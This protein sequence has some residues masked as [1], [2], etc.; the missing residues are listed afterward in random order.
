MPSSNVFRSQSSHVALLLSTVI[1]GATV[2]HLEKRAQP[3]GIDVSSYQSD[4]N[5]RTPSPRAFPSPTSERQKGPVRAMVCSCRTLT[6]D[7]SLKEPV[8]TSPSTLTLPML[9]SFTVP[10]TPPFLTSSPALLKQRF[11][12]PTVETGR[13]MAS[14]FQGPITSNVRTTFLPP[15][16]VAN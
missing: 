12:L 10:I 16:R 15:L 11:L 13:V 7:S 3:K 5:W 4:V 1:F 9:V 8:L 6:P 14:P 2:E